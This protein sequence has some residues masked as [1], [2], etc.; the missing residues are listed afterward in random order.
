MPII[1]TLS[2]RQ[3]YFEEQPTALS[4]ALGLTAEETLLRSPVPSIYRAAELFAA[5][6]NEDSPL[7][8]ASDAKDKIKQYGFDLTVPDEGIRQSALDILISRKQNEIRIQDTLSRSPDGFFPTTAKLATALGASLIDPLNIAS[9][10]IPVVGEARYSALLESAGGGVGRAMVRGRVGVMEG[11]VGAAVIEPFVAGAAIYE[12]ADYK[13]SNSIENI[14]FGGLFGGGLHM[15]AGAIG[16]ALSRGGSSYTSKPTGKMSETIDMLDP[17][18]RQ[19]ALKTAISQA[20]SGKEIDVEA[21][22]HLDPKFAPLKDRLLSS[23]S[24]TPFTE[25]KL[26]VNP[27]DPAPFLQLGAFGPS[28]NVTNGNRTT[29]IALKND[30]TPTV[31]ATFEEAEKLQKTI[32]RRS[33]ERMEIAKQPD[34]QFILRREFPEQPARDTSGNVFLFDNERAA[35][36]ATDSILALQDGNYSAVPIMVNDEMKWALVDNA[37]PE[38]VSA[39]KHSPDHVSFDVSHINRFTDTSMMKQTAP[40]DLT[41]LQEAIRQSY[42]PGRY[43]LSDQESSIAATKYLEEKSVK[44]DDIA[45]VDADIEYHIQKADSLAATLGIEKELAKDIEGYNLLVKDAE[46]ISRGIEAAATCSIRR[47]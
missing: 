45:A 21:I 36:K 19:Q 2:D 26:P 14:A 9:A 15:G 44:V 24:M 13:M 5:Y 3:P 8:A 10:F 23:T 4:T 30:G 46:D 42:K 39:A 17:T 37:S 28:A 20:M 41:R 43:R 38:F 25:V 27:T 12:Q 22:L 40:E 1:G 35:M 34:G 7:I 32:E 29:A 47:G 31:F 18:T 16:D 6:R 33:S 11:A